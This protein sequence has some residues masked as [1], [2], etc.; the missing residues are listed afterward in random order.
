MGADHRV[1]VFKISPKILPHLF[2]TGSFL[3]IIQGMPEGSQFRG[4]V[5]DGPTNCLYVH[6]EH[7]SFDIVEEGYASPEGT[8]E[9][10]T[11]DPGREIGV[12]KKFL[13]ARENHRD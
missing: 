9:L 4:C 1:K 6:V 13:Q 3:E 10:K 5:I 11:Y 12:M 7:P 8:I 2:R